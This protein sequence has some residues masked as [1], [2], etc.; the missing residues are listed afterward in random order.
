MKDRV[1]YGFLAGLGASAVRFVYG[2]IITFILDSFGYNITRWHDFAGSI[3]YG[4][5]PI[6]WYETAF[7]ELS[8]I[9][10]EATL[11]IGFA[12][13]IKHTTSSHYY[14]KGWLYGTVVWFSAFAVTTLFKAPGVEVI[15][16]ISTIINMSAAMLYGLALAFTSKRIVS[17][18]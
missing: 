16:A 8:V 13:F 2:W 14:F 7:A 15:S 3:L 10:F 4:F 5:K 11:G 18:H 12:Y 17:T 6:L 1:Y 9:G